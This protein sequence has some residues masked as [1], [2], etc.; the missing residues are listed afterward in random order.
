MSIKTDRQRRRLCS[1]KQ[2]DRNWRWAFNPKPGSDEATD[3]GCLCPV[4]DNAHGAGHYGD[5]DKY[6][7]VINAEC[8]LHG[9]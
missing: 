7:W 3:R 5:G 4:L 1:P 8:P 9:G 2:L 6:G